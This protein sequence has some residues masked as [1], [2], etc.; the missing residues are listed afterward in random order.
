[1][2]FA[3]LVVKNLL[4]Q[5][6]RAGLTL[7]GISLGIATIV[8][9]GVITSGLKGTAGA[10]VTS[11]GADFMLAQKGAAD[12]SFSVIPASEIDEV[13][14][15]TGVATARG[16]LFHITRAGNNPY[17]LMLGMSATDLA[18]SKPS[19]IQGRYFNL[20]AER[21]IVLGRG[22]SGNLN[23]G[24]GDTVVIDTVQFTVVGIY[25]SEVLWE[26]SGAFAPL[27]TV[28]AM[29]NRED[30]VSVIHVTV[31]EGSSVDEVADRIEAM[32][33]GLVAIVTAEDIG[34]VDSGYG[35]IDAANIAI[36]GLAIVIGG[37]G[38]MNTMVMAI[39]ERTREIGV[40]RAVGWSGRRVV[41]MILTE[42]L[43][44]CLGAAA[45]GSLLGVVVSR[46]AL[47]SPGVS[48]LLEP[49]YDP[50]IFA[51]ALVVAFAVALAGAIYPAFRAVRLTPMEALRY[52]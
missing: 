12:L 31:A 44:L 1:M 26:E 51:Q 25:T 48:G 47:L 43:I 37:I 13:R 2:S 7:I 3:A 39:F 50:A 10:F 33:P 32:V 4:R 6:V 49:D 20:G 28:Q 22:A 46:A 40:L 21:E 14:N 27:A 36:S 18:E 45:A 23:A 17:F 5:R 38:V 24:V 29:A 35:L 8:A 19:L 41:G 15:V 34:Q 30:A 52:E 16:G 42:A 11:R 9:L